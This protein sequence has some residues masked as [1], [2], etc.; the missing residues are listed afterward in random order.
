MVRIKETLLL[1]YIFEVCL[2]MG[3]QFVDFICCIHF[4]NA[5]LIRS[6]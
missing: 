6:V 2:V 1:S 4:V 3:E 5:K